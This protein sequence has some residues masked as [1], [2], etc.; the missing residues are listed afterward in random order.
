[1]SQGQWVARSGGKNVEVAKPR[2]RITVPRFDNT[3]LIASYSKTLIGRCMNPHKQDMKILLFMLPRIWNV[4]GRVAG[5]D[6]G[7]GRFQF[8]FD[9]EEDI[10][11]VLKMEPFHFDY[12]MISLVRWRPVLE[13]NYPS[14]I[15]FWVRVLDIPLQFRAA[16]TFQSVGEAIGVVQ[17]PVDLAGGRVRVEVDGFKP[18][19]FSMEIDFE[20][21]VEITVALRYEKLFGFCRECSRLTHEQARCPSLKK[22]DTVTTV[23]GGAGDEGT[24]DDGSNATSFRAAVIHGS[25]TQGDRRDGQS[26]RSQMAKG[27][28][29]GKGIARQKQGHYRKEDAYHP[30]REKFLKGYGEGSS[31]NG[32]Q[33]GY[34]DRRMGVQLRGQHEGETLSKNPTKLMLD[35]FKGVKHGSVMEVAPVVAPD[36]KGSGSNARKALF[37]EDT[38]PVASLVAQAQEDKLVEEA[39]VMR[40]QGEIGEELNEVDEQMLHSQALDEANLMVE[41]VVLSDTELLLEDGEELEDWEQGE[42]MDFAEEEET[43]VENQEDLKQNDVVHVQKEA[44]E[45]M[46]EDTADE[47]EI[48]KKG[49]KLESG[50]TGGPSKKRGVPGFVSPRKKLLALAAAKQGDKAKKAPPK[51]KHSAA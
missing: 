11:E 15:T 27:M 28:D 12:W 2:L 36:E 6:L 47:K 19:V 14:K 5:V 29:K 9:L 46:V 38:V 35:A 22:E 32:K 33:S 44:E 48:K 37:T 43:K 16:E 20:E 40:E 17:G 21:G 30:Y 45:Q 3:E 51:P 13:P 49:G 42:I 50:A 7:L 4:E 23:A 8:A 34:G 25:K 26:N 41:G 24:G 1:M 10:A 39:K 18:M 31:F